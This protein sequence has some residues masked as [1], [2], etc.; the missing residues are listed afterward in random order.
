MAAKKKPGPEALQ[1]IVDYLKSD[2]SAS[3]AD[4]RVAAEK[5]GFIVWPIMYGKAKAILGMVP[6]AKRGHGKAAK[7]ARLGRPA[8]TATVAVKRGPGRPPKA[9]ASSSALGS[10][11]ALI[12]ALKDGESE[13]HR[14]RRALDQ[15]RGILESLA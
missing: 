7:A 6:V 11:D 9:A 5:K 4:V 3:Y 1:F 10:L 2:K 14:L 8:A 15:I 12:G 13:R